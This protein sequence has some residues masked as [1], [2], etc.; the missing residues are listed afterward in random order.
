[1]LRLIAQAL[2][3]SVNA[4]FAGKALNIATA[5]LYFGTNVILAAVRGVAI[6]I[7]VAFFA[8]SDFTPAF[9]TGC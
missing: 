7:V 2:A 3:R 8:C 4:R 5:A 1:M 6:T 9:N